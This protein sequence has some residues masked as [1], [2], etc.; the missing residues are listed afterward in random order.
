MTKAIVLDSGPLGRLTHA[1][2]SRNQDIRTW[3]SLLLDREIVVFLPEIADYEIRRNLIV[4]NLKGSLAN[5]DDLPSLITYLPITTADMRLAAELWAKSRKTGRSIGDPK[6]LNADVIIA[7]Q[8][9]RYGAVI[10]TDNIGHLGQFTEARP[11]TSIK[12]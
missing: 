4:E 10:A 8:A 2:Y 9:I 6:E 12:P 11:W 7:A 5:L 3:L 1:D